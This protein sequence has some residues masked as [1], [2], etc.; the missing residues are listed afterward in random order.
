[1]STALHR[2]MSR[3]EFLDWA[4]GEDAPYE[5]DGAGPVAMTG[6]S[7]FHDM[8][9]R[10][11]QR[12][13]DDQLTGTACTLFGPEAGLETV[14][15][16]VRYPDALVTCQPQNLRSKLVTGVVVVLEVLSPSTARLDRIIKA[17]EY[18]AVPSIRRYVLLEQ[19]S[20][21][22]TV[23]AKDADEQ[24]RASMLTDDDRLELPEIGVAFRL[25]DVYKGFPSSS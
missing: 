25:G 9:R 19:D 7:L 14:G 13:I 10:R 11:L 2:P 4:E 18:G 8:V 23:F 22:A 20:A 24:W 1:M 12:L 21:G 17:R 16:A 3:D 5:F 15:G 6:G